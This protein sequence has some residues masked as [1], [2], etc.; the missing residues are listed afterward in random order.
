MLTR[1]PVKGTQSSKQSLESFVK[2]TDGQC[3]T[4]MFSASEDNARCWE[5]SATPEPVS[6]WSILGRRVPGFV[7][8]R[9][10]L[11][12]VDT[13]DILEGHGHH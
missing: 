6:W 3:P 11:S 4:E 1:I 5:S 8:I 7:G 10:Y 13:V 12:M 9:K 2:C